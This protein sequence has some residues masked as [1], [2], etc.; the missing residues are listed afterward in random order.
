M[1]EF[2]F[3]NFVG[4]DFCAIYVAFVVCCECL[5]LNFIPFA[6]TRDNWWGHILLHFIGC[7]VLLHCIFYI[8]YVC[9]RIFYILCVPHILYYV[10]IPLSGVSALRVLPWMNARTFSAVCPQ[11]TE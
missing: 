1:F 2:P 10:C 8:I 3:A 7:I 11:K 9:I 4:L 5:G 6:F